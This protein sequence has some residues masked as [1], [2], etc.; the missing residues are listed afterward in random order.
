MINE[1]YVYKRWENLDQILKSNTSYT[2]KNYRI[3]ALSVTKNKIFISN[4][5]EGK[6]QVLIEFHREELKDYSPIQI[7]GLSISI[8]ENPLISINNIYL[9][10]ALIDLGLDE[11]F[12]AFTTSIVIRIQDSQS[13]Y[14]TIEKIERIFKEYLD[15]FTRKTEKCLSEIQEQGLFAEL[16]ELFT[17]VKSIGDSAVMYWEGP[18][19]GRRDFVLDCKEVEIKSIIKI[20]DKTVT[21]TSENQLEP[22]DLPL[23]LHLYTL[24]KVNNGKTII[25][26]VNQIFTDLM[27][28][29][30]KKALLGKLFLLGVDIDTYI[31]DNRYRVVEIISYNID[32]NFPRI[33]KADIPAEVFDVKYKLD[34][35]LI[36]GE[37]IFDEKK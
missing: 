11:A 17:Q 16:S 24:E 29:S 22:L 4:N 1:Y 36:K 31:S 23:Y 10:I 28:I 12:L 33:K 26:L 27:T 20:N 5:I 6:R 18:T 21:I 8:L 3:E 13:D 35:K 15:F 2:N 30:S 32:D 34:L 19:K 37:L 14:E 7:N 25:D 9:T